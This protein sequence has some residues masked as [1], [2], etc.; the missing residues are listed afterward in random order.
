[1]D[2][3]N[4]P[5]AFVYSKRGEL[6]GSFVAGDAIEH[7]QTTRNGEV[8]I[9]YFDE[10]AC[11]GGDLE[12]SGL[13]CFDETGR[14]L[15]QYWPDIAEPNSLPCIDDCYAL[16]VSADDVWACYY[17]SFPLVRLRSRR[18]EQ[19][20]V[21]WP[22]KAVRSFA[23]HNERMLMV[24]AYRDG[25]LYSVHLQERT[26]YEVSISGP[27]GEPLQFDTSF[28]RGPLLCFASLKDPLNQKL[29][30]VDLRT[31]P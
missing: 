27:D 16:N 9:G 20:W 18:L 3:R 11:S 13:V 19:A 23:V 28:S 31:I 30:M 26:L 14:P 10:G 4:T 7:V 6:I 12:Q 17:S 29:F 15:L 5:N 24:A 2:K 25:L 8:W 21:D 1:M 22:G